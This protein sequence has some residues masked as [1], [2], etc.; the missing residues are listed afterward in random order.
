MENR[1]QI[2][3]Q[4][5]VELA[6]EGTKNGDFPFGA[7]IVLDNKVI[8]EHHNESFYKKEVYRH[9][10]LL[11]LAEAQKK[12]SKEELS[13]C[14]IYTSVEPCAMCSFAIQELNIQRVVFGL[15]S[16]IMGGYSKWQILQDDQVNIAFPNS[17]GRKPEITA[18]VYKDGVIDGWKKWNRDKWEV[19]CRKGVF[20]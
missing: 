4:R 20:E 13:R 15:R 2:Y 11:V 9:A 12:L 7:L 1:D 10:E 17:F 16:P 6:A 3:I 5:C 8:S 18:D 14:T 19:F